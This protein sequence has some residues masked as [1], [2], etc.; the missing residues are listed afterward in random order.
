ML[1][2][3]YE[4]GTID[5]RIVSQKS[6]SFTADFVVIIFDGLSQ[7]P[8][9]ARVYDNSAIY[10]ICI[11][12]QNDKKLVSCFVSVRRNDTIA[13]V[14]TNKV[15]LSPLYNIAANLPNS[16]FGKESKI[17]ITTKKQ[18]AVNVL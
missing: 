5:E 2:G 12:T 7:I 13:P 15:N 6:I 10:I 14:Q 1:F 17:F 18:K 4:R 8:I 16:S 9:Y 11:V 3:N